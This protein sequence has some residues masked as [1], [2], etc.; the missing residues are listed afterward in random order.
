MKLGAMG[1]IRRPRNRKTG[2]VYDDRW[3]I[4]WRDHTGA[5][6]SRVIHK[7]KPHA[8]R[9]LRELER[10]ADFQAVGIPGLATQATPLSEL[11]DEWKAEHADQWSDHH[12]EAVAAGL[13]VVMPKIRGIARVQDLTL[14][15]VL[16]LRSRMKQS[17]RT[18]NLYWGY[19]RAALAWAESSGRIQWN[20]LRALKALPQ[21]GRHRVRARR[22]MT[23]EEARK[24]LAAADAHDRQRPSYIPQAPL[25]EVLLGTGMRLGEAIRVEWRDV[26]QASITVRAPG[27]GGDP[28]EVPL[29]PA[30]AGRL[31]ALRGTHGRWIGR[32]PRETDR[33]FVSARGK[34]YEDHASQFRQLMRAWRELSGIKDVDWHTTRHTYATWLAEAGVHVAEAQRR[35][36]HRSAA[37]TL[38]VYTHVKATASA[39]SVPDLRAESASVDAATGAS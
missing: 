9:L 31:R 32:L 38:G 36:G 23:A 6:R 10:S 13:K 35:L 19:L 12:R 29:D 39:P 3:E 33:A 22:A 11:I 4:L 17:N 27:K 7:P 34:P 2:D 24:L 25:L 1:H 14:E 37:V 30:L 20:P 18:R 28:R 15:R 5:L 8:K 26:G 16:T 21:A